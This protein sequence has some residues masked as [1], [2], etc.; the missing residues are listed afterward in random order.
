MNQTIKRMT[1]HAVIYVLLSLLFGLSIGQ[2]G[3]ELELFPLN[4][5]NYVALERTEGIRVVTRE[6]FGDL[7]SDDWATYINY[8]DDFILFDENVEVDVYRQYN[9]AS[10]FEDYPADIY[11]G[12]LMGPDFSTSPGSERFITRIT[13]ECD[14]GINFAGHYTFVYWGCGT[15]CASGVIV[16][17]KTGEIFSQGIVSTKGLAFQ[18]DSSLLIRNEGSI[19]RE[20]HLIWL[21]S[22]CVVTHELW[23]GTEF[24]ELED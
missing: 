21:C 16:D 2:G 19:D 14:K 12:E 17:R 5:E 23:T 9:F 1:R 8:D 11:E 4:N 22:Y 20:T 13:N 7:T 3:I 18:R 10:T 24:V 6:E 15:N